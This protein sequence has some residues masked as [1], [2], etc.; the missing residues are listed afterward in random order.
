[1]ARNGRKSQTSPVRIIPLGGLGE[2]GMNMM[3][4]ETDDDAV[5]I[6]CGV[7]FPEY[8]TPGI[9][10]VIPNME[11]VESIA[12]RL[13]A[14]LITHGHLDH[15]GSIPYLMNTVKAPIYAPR[16]A[17]EMIRNELRKAR[18][19]GGMDVT[20]VK[21]RQ[22]Y[23]FGDISAQWLEMCHSIPDSCSIY[24]DTPQGGIFHTGDF[25]L[26]I[27]P[28]IGFPTDYQMLSEI[29][30]RG[31]RL[32]MSD[33]T[34]AEDEGSSLSDRVAAEAIYGAIAEASG[35]VIIASFSTQV[36]R[37]QMVADAA[38]AL[39][40]R[41]VLLGR[42]MIETSELAQQTG[43]LRIPSELEI[44][45]AEA[46]SLPD[47]QVAIITTGTQGEF[48][49]GVVRMARGDH[50]EVRLSK[51]DTVILSA[52]TIPGNEMAVNEVRNNL[53]MRN[54]RVITS[55]SRPIHVSGHAKREEL[56]MMFNVLRP[57]SFTPIH[58][59]F[60]M[61]RAHCDLALDMGVPEENVNL[62]VDGDV[63]ELDGNGVGVSG[64][65]PFGNV[66]IQGQG[67][68]D[69]AGSVMEERK[70]L[71][72]DGI[73]F[74][75]LARQNGKIVGT[76]QM[77]TSGFVDSADAPALMRDA[78]EVLSDAIEP[79]AGK[80]LDWDETDRLVRAALGRFFSRRTKRKP[81]IT[82]TEIDVRPE[83]VAGGKRRIT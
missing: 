6:D 56:K 35:R 8:N 54:V 83:R 53:A 9:E 76:P 23:S 39:G 3:V 21:T 20:T 12:D 42:S 79:V 19:R 78:S 13:R 81:L 31:V 47:N 17:S 71:S 22:E 58:G 14:I 34:N 60:R 51:E 1:M 48:A 50:R 82:V 5:I 69:P 26:D 65:V 40:R 32:L 43:H 24:L 38:L 63:L 70:S 36:A 59:E 64:R 27:E 73:V 11:Y 75:A 15:I 49:A 52:R 37:V 72:H 41:I 10:R 77:V 45:M 55:S 80:S 2:V 57:Q 4:L 7:Q 44:S 16:L 25:K 68:W 66:L 74:V 67:Q 46:N 29:G 18:H 28:M 30:R 33:S 61:L 62:I